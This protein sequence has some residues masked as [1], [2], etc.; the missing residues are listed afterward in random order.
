MMESGDFEPVETRHI[1]RLVEGVG[2]VVNVGANIGYYCCLALNEGKKVVAFEPMP[3]NH[4]Y[5]FRNVF[6]NGWSKDFECYPIALSQEI[7]LIE[8]FGAGTGASL[9]R[10]WAGQNFSTIVPVSTLDVVL[11]ERFLAERILIIVDVEGAEYEMLKGAS[12]LLFSDVSPIW[13]VEIS[14]RDHQPEGVEINPN[15]LKTFELFLNNG[16]LAI[17]ADEKPRFIGLEEIQQIE[18]TKKDTLNG[19][20]FIFVS[21]S[22]ADGVFSLLS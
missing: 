12:K 10:G 14:V 2:T 11:G 1:K 15:L 17:T 4:K 7:G 5:L 16:Y 21:E 8:I 9:I 20:N 22:S 3:S 18:L 13:F 6:I 19:H